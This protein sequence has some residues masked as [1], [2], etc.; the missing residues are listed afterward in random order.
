MHAH[1]H[2]ARP[3]VARL[4]RLCARPVLRRGTFC[5]RCVT[6]LC[7]STHSKCCSSNVSLRILFFAEFAPICT[8]ALSEGVDKLFSC[9]HARRDAKT[10][11][12]RQSKRDLVS[13]HIVCCRVC[14]YFQMQIPRVH[15]CH[16]HGKCIPKMILSVHRINARGSSSWRTR[17]IH[18]RGGVDRVN[19]ISFHI[20]SRHYSHSRFAPNARVRAR[21]SQK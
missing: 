9:V 5:G 18:N 8:E 19:S 10:A 21:C 12:R 15:L 14:K 3:P 16:L 13:V 4:V 2:V 17:T 20:N 6:G 11:E 7:A 1:T